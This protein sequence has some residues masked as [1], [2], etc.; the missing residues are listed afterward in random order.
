MLGQVQDVVQVLGYGTARGGA[1]VGVVGEHAGEFRVGAGAAGQVG[2]RL[3]GDT[4]EQ[5]LEHGVPP[6]VG[7]QVQGGVRADGGGHEPG[8]VGAQGVLDDRQG[9]G[10]RHEVGQCLEDGAAFVGG[11]LAVDAGEGGGVGPGR[12]Q[13]EDAGRLRQVGAAAAAG[14]GDPQLPDGDGPVGARV[15]GRLVECLVQPGAGGAVE[16]AV[17]AGVQGGEGRRGDVR[18]GTEGVVEVVHGVLPS[19][20]VE[21]S[22]G[23]GG[24]SASGGVETAAAWWRNGRDCWA[25]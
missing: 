23:I 2:H 4:G 5:A 19:E 20:S 7:V 11:A 6:V 12:V 25:S 16:P 10:A 15:C 13:E 17:Q 24:R 21:P 1:F 18:R 8:V 9:V 14:L 22:P 3:D